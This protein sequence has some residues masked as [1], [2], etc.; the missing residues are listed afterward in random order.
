MALI[1]CQNGRDGVSVWDSRQTS[2][3]GPGS[4]NTISGNL[5]SGIY[6]YGPS[7]ETWIYSNYIGLDRT[8]S[9]SLGNQRFGVHLDNVSNNFIGGPELQLRNIISG[10]ATAPIVIQGAAATNNRVQNNFVGT[11]AAGNAALVNANTGILIVDASSNIIGTDGDGISD[12][13]ERNVISG[14]GINGAIGLQNAS[15]NIIAGNFLG[16]D[17]TGS[18]ALANRGPGISLVLGSSNNRIGT[19]ADGVS[20][21]LESNVIAGHLN[22]ALRVLSSNGNKIAG[23]RIGTDITGTQSLP[24]AGYGIWIRGQDNVIGVPAECTFRHDWR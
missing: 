10:N 13:V 14:Q 23:N 6:V 18:I 20:D 9:F 7:Q 1:N 19:N 5:R 4:R 17:A 24:N 8:G 2:I 15:S 21:E 3:G 12:A 16:T 11:N 22:Y